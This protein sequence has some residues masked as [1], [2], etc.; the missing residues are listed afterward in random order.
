MENESTTPGTEVVGL[1]EDQAVQE[2]LGRW[3][4]KEKSEP[5]PKEQ[6]TEED[7]EQ[8]TLE[9]PQG[10]ATA[11]EEPETEEVADSDVE[12]DVAGEKFK[13]P[14]S[15]SELAKRIEAKAKEVEAGATRKFQE[16]ADLRK[17]VETEREAV[18]QLRKFAEANADLLADHRMVAK[19]LQTLENI[20]VNELDTD[21]LTRLNAEYNQLQAARGRI[22]L[23]IRE[24]GGKMAQEEQKAFQARRELSEKA[25][26]AKIKGWGPD[27]AKKLAEYAIA[28]GAPPQALNGIT[29]AWMV[30]I[31]DDAAYGHQMRQAK[32]GIE[33]R[34]A[35]APAK[36]L[37]PNSGTK[38]SAQLKADAA[39]KQV[40][41]TG[42][43]QDAAAAF[44]ARANLRKR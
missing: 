22:E 35:Q 25:L 18:T 19:R 34:V 15:Q 7:Q 20:N 40:R 10:D 43:V 17:A 27:H 36:T 24:N 42:S 6:A 32:P 37:S 3:G 12:I 39:M 9:Q 23:Q 33:K 38:P 41:K 11:E 29:D 28:K 4:K 1:T 30:E 44:L 31:L 2:M 5:E 16:A 14:A 21:T 13:V 26:S 8:P